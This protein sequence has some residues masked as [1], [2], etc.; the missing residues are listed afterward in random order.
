MSDTLNTI[1]ND[2]KAMS[3]EKTA[4]IYQKIVVNEKVLGVNRGPLR[5]MAKAYIPNHDLGLELWS[6]NTL[7]TRLLAAMILEPKKLSIIDL[8][9][10][11]NQTQ[12]VSLIDELTFE[13]FETFQLTTELFEDW[14]HHPDLMH[15]RAAWN[16]AIVQ[17]HRKRMTD[18]EAKELIDYIENHLVNAPE[19]VK[20]AMNRC[21]VE[22]GVNYKAYTERCLEIGASLG[23][24]K[25]VMVAKGCTSPYA[26]DWIHAILR[27][28][29]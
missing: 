14:L 25:E 23:V 13:V 15:Q 2:L 26:P 20:Y 18:E 19:L 10:L 1:L 3:N 28:K 9:A 24:Y 5:Q 27:R 17:V 12:S 22:I 4:R 16:S 6:T 11:L 7:E 21:L 29:N 8:D